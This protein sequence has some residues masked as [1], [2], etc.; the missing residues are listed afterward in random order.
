MIG[1]QVFCNSYCRSTIAFYESLSYIFEVPLRICL[2]K[3]GLGIRG[4]IGFIEEEFSHIE[5]VHTLNEIDAIFALQER[6]NWHHI[7]GV[8]QASTHIQKTIRYAI[9]MKFMYG[10]A[11]EAPCNMFA[12]GIS[13]VA[14][15]FYIKN[16]AKRA[17]KDIITR[18]EFIINWSGDDSLALQEFGWDASK[19]IPCGYFSPPLLR[20][21]FVKRDISYL[22]SVHIL[23]TGEMTWHRGH[24]VLLEAL[25]ILKSWGVLVRTTFTGQGPLAN[26]LRNIAQ[27]NNLNCSFPGSVSMANLI[28]LYQSCSLFVAPGRQEP[29]GMRVNDALNCG[30]PTIVSRGMGASKLIFDYGF[31]ITFA[32]ND[33]VDLAWQIRR[34]ISEPAIY[35][36]ICNNLADMHYHI[37]P[38]SAAERVAGILYHSFDEWITTVN[39]DFA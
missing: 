12:P 19:I 10:I 13:R 28:E 34:L 7:F 5:F 21:K 27:E 31:G 20:S 39:G 32:T 30:L 15:D 18:A 22:K 17:L 11:S 24:E 26:K 35:Q 16:I 36:S 3:K 33:A 6:N 23:C 8:Y 1:L 4:D 37:L 9:K 25:I 38:N 2:A 29:W 14:K